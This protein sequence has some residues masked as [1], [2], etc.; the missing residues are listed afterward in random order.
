VSDSKGRQLDLTPEALQTIAA[1]QARVAAVAAHY[2]ENS[3]EHAEIADSLANA[4][5]RMIGLGGRIMCDGRED[6]LCL[7]GASFIT[8]GVVFFPLREG[9]QTDPLRGTWSLHS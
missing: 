3:P 2:G 4:L 7:L 8:Y 9:G 5:A 6:E 1:M